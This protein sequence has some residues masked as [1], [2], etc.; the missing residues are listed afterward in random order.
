MKNRDTNINAMRSNHFAGSGWDDLDFSEWKEYMLKFFI[1]ANKVL[2]LPIPGAVV[3]ALKRR[4]SL[5]PRS[6]PLKLIFE[7]VGC[8]E[9]K[10]KITSKNTLQL[11]WRLNI[12]SHTP[13]KSILLNKLFD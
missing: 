6:T 13:N 2:N 8:T 10:P 5:S 9:K 7:C 4:I 11:N 1:L 12:T 3:S